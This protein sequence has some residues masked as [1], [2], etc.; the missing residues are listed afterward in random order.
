[1]NEDQIQADANAD[2]PFEKIT[3]SPM[4]CENSGET[5]VD[6]YMD[7]VDFGFELGMATGGNRVYASVEDLKERSRC[8]AS[9]GIVKVRVQFLELVEPGDT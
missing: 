4:G 3:L 9:C 1:M 7:R 6:C 2:V 8:V 5:F